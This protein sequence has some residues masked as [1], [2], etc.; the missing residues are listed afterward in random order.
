MKRDIRPSGAE[1][2]DGCTFDLKQIFIQTT[3]EGSN[4]IG[5]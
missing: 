4:L 1:S 2:K 5:S 3:H